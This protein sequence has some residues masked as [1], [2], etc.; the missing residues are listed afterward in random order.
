MS[1]GPRRVVIIGGGIV[2]LATALALRESSPDAPLTVLEKESEVGRHQTGHNSGVLHAGVY[3]P[4][5]S[6]KARLCADGRARMEAFCATH[7]VPFTRCGKLVVATREAELPRLETLRER[8]VANGLAVEVLDRDALRE[9]EP[10]A[11]GLRALR[12]PESGVVDYGEVAR[13]MKAALIAQGVAVRT[14]QS[15]RGVR[16]MNHALVLETGTGEVESDFVVNCGGLH[17]DRLARRFGLDPGIRIVPF[18]GE[19]FHLSSAGAAKVRA[20]IYPVPDPDL[21]FLGVHLTRGVHGTVEAGPNA[22]LAFAREGYRRR[23]LSP[24]D[25]I[26]AFAFPGFWRMAA[27]WWRTAA[28]EWRRSLD[29]G[30]F[31]RDLQRLVPSLTRDDLRPGGSGVRAQAVDRDGRLAD[32]FLFVEG[33]RSLH[34]LNAPS[35]AATASLAIGR[36][37]ARRARERMAG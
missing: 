22:V 2:G 4:P 34:V 30:L 17:A 29:P 28:Y 8:A 9:V 6:L 32:D 12:V 7:G 20:L 11:A 35:P 3:Y 18:R 10:H 31:L 37:I 23:D 13:A 21:P 27:R 25:L 24:G 1:P 5:G 14:G 15:L 36:E 19:Y 33:P 26:E 16:R